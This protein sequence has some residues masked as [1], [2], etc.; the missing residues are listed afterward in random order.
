MARVS[1]QKP[2][3]QH[4]SDASVQRR[5]SPSDDYFTSHLCGFCATSLGLRSDSRSAHQATLQSFPAGTSGAMQNYAQV[6]PSSCAFIF[7]ET[8]IRIRVRYS[9]GILWWCHS[10]KMADHENCVPVSIGFSEMAL[11]HSCF[12]CQLVVSLLP[13]PGFLAKN[14]LLSQAPEWISVPGIA[15]LNLS[16]AERM[17]CPVRQLKLYLRD[18]ERIQGGGRQRL[19]IHWNRN[20]RDIMKSQISRWIGE[21]V[22]EAP[23][24]NVLDDFSKQIQKPVTYREYDR[25][26]AHEVRALSASWSY[27][28]QVA[29]PD[30]LS[31]AFWRSSGIFQNSYLR[32]MVC[33]ADG[34]STHWVQWWSHNTSWI[35]D[36]FTHLHSLHDLYAATATTFLM[37]ITWLLAG[38]FMYGRE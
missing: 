32:D 11:L 22:K 28:C 35:Q 31:A 12:E 5:T 27:N 21:T 23:G 7:I 38:I 25:V 29:L 8:A 1:S 18:S 36:I 2:S 14:Q 34:M 24:L 17:L 26:T 13:E 33:I 37:K 3:F 19:F 20:I 16:E 6:G 10:L 15:H 9:R 30:I 4:L